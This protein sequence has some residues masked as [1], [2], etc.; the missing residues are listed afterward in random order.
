VAALAVVPALVTW[1]VAHGGV[2]GALGAL[3]NGSR[4]E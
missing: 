2:R 1:L 3:W 4:R